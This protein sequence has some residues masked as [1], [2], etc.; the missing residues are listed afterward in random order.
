MGNSLMGRRRSD[1]VLNPDYVIGLAELSNDDLL[2]RRDEA[3]QEESDVSYIRRLIQGRLDLL[4]F[5]VSR[6]E[7]AQGVDVTDQSNDDAALV[8]ALTSVL[9][10]KH[11]GAP[12]AAQ[13]AGTRALPV[14]V[15]RDP[16]VAV[17]SRRSAE[18]AVADVRFSDLRS[19]SEQELTE[20]IEKFSALERDVSKQR[21]KVQ[22]VADV[23]AEAVEQ[24]VANGSM[25]ANVM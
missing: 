4:R 24:R 15:T 20:A 1:R 12:R 6:R 9:T 13:A 11:R 5:E 3:L 10:D 14:H 18:S 7:Q 23:L 22:E 8:K 21:S 19:L 16:Q 2:E 25:S 17:F